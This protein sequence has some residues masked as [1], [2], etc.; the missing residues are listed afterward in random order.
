MCQGDG[1]RLLGQEYWCPSRPESSCPLAAWKGMIEGSL[2][3]LGIGEKDPNAACQTSKLWHVQGAA[4]G[5]VVHSNAFRL[6][7]EDK[8]PLI[9]VGST[10]KGNRP[11][12]RP[13]FWVF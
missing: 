2:K 7:N 5:R 13:S 3:E 10:G 4:F 6:V 11:W 12:H 9:V 1:C 8:M